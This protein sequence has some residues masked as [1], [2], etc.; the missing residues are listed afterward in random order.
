TGCRARCRAR[1]GH[2]RV[3]Q[4]R[5]AQ[6]RGDLPGGGRRMSATPEARGDRPVRLV[7]R[8]EF[9]ER[10]RDRG[11]QISTGIT[12]LILV[13]LIVANSFTK[14]GASYEL[15]V[16]SS[17]ATAQEIGKEVAAAGTAQEVQVGIQPLGSQA[18]A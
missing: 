4:R 18:D 5:P 13:G 9:T 10:F 6:P 2:G 3:V 11:F 15:G 12:L 14:G 7:A 16:S 1:G 8:R 17:D